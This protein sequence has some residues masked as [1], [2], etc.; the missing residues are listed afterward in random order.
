MQSEKERFF[1]DIERLVDNMWS[2]TTF[3]SVLPLFNI[4]AIFTPSVESGIGVG[5]V[6]KDTMFGLYRDGTEL[7]G[8]YPSKE[9]MLRQICKLTGRFACD[10]PSVIANDDFYGGLGGEFVISTRFAKSL[11]IRS[12]TSGV[13]VLRHEMGHNF[14]HV[15]EE[16]DGGDVYS[17]VNSASQISGLSWSHWLSDPKRIK[18]EREKLKVQEYGSYI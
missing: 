9:D 8:I 3:A 4:W 14:I 7:R 13:I 12:K 18:E 16:Y 2:G 1:K 17:G 5:G 15:G 6:P 10:F 11:I